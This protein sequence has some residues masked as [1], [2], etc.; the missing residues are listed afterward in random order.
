[1]KTFKKGRKKF[2]EQ[3]QKEILFTEGVKL[4]KQTLLSIVYLGPVGPII[5]ECRNAC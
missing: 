3:Q 1:M 5:D 4:P 2:V